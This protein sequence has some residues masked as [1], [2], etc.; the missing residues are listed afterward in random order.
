MDDAEQYLGK[1]ILDNAI[2]YLQDRNARE[3]TW[4]Y[5][6]NNARYRLEKISKINPDILPARLV[7]KK[8]RP[9]KKQWEFYQKALFHAV[10]GLGDVLNESA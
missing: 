2:G 9:R 8:P 7:V 5:Y 1:I 4:H 3:W 10:E 6:L